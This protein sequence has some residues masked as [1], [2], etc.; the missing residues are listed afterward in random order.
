MAVGLCAAC[1]GVASDAGAG[2]HGGSLTRAGAAGVGGSTAGTGAA[3]GGSVA[4]A[5]AAGAG[6]E[7]FLRVAGANFYD[8]GTPYDYDGVSANYV[9]AR[10]VIRIHGERTK[11]NVLWGV[12]LEVPLTAMAEIAC[13]DK[14]FVDVSQQD[15]NAAGA[16][17]ITKSTRAVG[18]LAKCTL[19]LA[20]AGSVGEAVAGSFTGT[21]F[22]IMSPQSGGSGVE[23]SFSVTRGADE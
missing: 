2:G 9:A 16:P 10:D 20:R 3:A 13:D 22:N 7:D 17:A 23:G 8:P 5:G 1:G 19:D 11:D 12:T 21:V 4:L 14:T 18:G 15:L 6:A